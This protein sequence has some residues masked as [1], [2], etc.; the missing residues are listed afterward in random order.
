MVRIFQQEFVSTKTR[1]PSDLQCNAVY[2]IPCKDCPWNYI[3]ETERCFKTRRKEHQRNLKN[4]AKGPNVANHAWQNNHSIVLLT[5]A[6]TAYENIRILAH[7]KNCRRG[8]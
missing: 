8:K 4:Y 7:S 6:I 5:K 1:Q 2:K 3:G